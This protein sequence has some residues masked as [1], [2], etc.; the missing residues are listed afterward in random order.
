MSRSKPCLPQHGWHFTRR[1][2]SCR[3]GSSA[4]RLSP[5]QASVASRRR[6]YHAPPR[7]VDRKHP[8]PNAPAGVRFWNGSAVSPGRPGV[9]VSPRRRAGNAGVDQRNLQ[10]QLFGFHVAAEGGGA[11]WSVN[12]R[13]Y[14]LSPWSNDPV[15]DRPGEAFFVVDG[16][17]S[18]SSLPSRACPAPLAP[19]SRRATAWDSRFTRLA[20]ATSS[21]SRPD[22]PSDD[23]VKNSRLRSP[24]GATAREGCGSTARWNGSSAPTATGPRHFITHYPRFRDDAL[25]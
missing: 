5:T 17:P 18:R 14:R 22:R 9:C 16:T 1:T 23:A 24:T 21:R 8:R 4:P 15:I 6:P 13:D 20:T 10:W 7:A 12:S 3:P 19:S 11:T 25:T 2:A